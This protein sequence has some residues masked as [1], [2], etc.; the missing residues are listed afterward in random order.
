MSGKVS[1]GSKWESPW[2]SEEMLFRGVGVEKRGRQMGIKA[3]KH[4]ARGKGDSSL[5][6]K[7]GVHGVEGD[8]RGLYRGG[9]DQ[10]RNS[11]TLP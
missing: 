2:V 9:R 5:L 3:R 11:I 10:I 6:L 1:G 8:E 7:C 4:G